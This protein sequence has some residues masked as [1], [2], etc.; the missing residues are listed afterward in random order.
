MGR[1][2]ILKE[3]HCDRYILA[4]TDEQLHKAALALMRERLEGGWYSDDVADRAEHILTIEDEVARRKKAWRF[5]QDQSGY[6][7]EGIDLEE[8]QILE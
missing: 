5:I 3:K 7:Y 8:L 2:L 4:D 1:I 6:E